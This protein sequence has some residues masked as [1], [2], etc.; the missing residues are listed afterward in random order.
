MTTH[1]KPC[2]KTQKLVSN[3]HRC[4]QS[5]VM[6]TR[7]FGPRPSTENFAFSLSSLPF[8]WERDSFCFLSVSLEKTS[9]WYIFFSVF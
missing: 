7:I 3:H 5:S 8:I 6:E 2:F 4:L 1:S 9:S